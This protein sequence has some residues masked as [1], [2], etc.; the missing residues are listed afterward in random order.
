MADQKNTKTQHH[1]YFWRGFS[2]ALSLSARCPLCVSKSKSHAIVYFS[3]SA[4]TALKSDWLSV[5]R[6]MYAALDLE[7]ANADG[8][9]VD[10]DSL[11]YHG[12]SNSH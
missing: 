2:S 11:A 5:G 4:E 8:P 10:D 1:G 7:L 3:R 6:D 9:K 12:Q